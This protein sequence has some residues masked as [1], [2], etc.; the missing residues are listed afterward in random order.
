MLLACTTPSPTLATISFG[1]TSFLCACSYPLPSQLAQWHTPPTIRARVGAAMLLILFILSSG[2]G[3]VLVPWVASLV[4]PGD[5][6][7]RAL[8]LVT[9]AAGV[10]GLLNWFGLDRWL[11]SGSPAA[12]RASP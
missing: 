9:V 5:G 10:L 3:P 11:R 8:A 7:G 4:F 2:L 12:M 6:L 1:F